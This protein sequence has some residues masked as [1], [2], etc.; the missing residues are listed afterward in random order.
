MLVNF[1]MGN[2]KFQLRYGG[3]GLDFLPVSLKPNLLA[4]WEMSHSC[5]RCPLV[6]P[7][8][9]KGSAAVVQRV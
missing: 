1:L 8:I 9:R 3:Q 2:E 4:V 5:F 7:V 6:D